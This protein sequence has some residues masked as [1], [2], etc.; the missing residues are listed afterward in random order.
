MILFF[1]TRYVSS[2]KLSAARWIDWVR[3]PK[4]VPEAASE[5]LAAVAA[6]RLQPPSTPQPNVFTTVQS[7][8]QSHHPLILSRELEF[9]PPPHHLEASRRPITWLETL[10]CVQNIKLGLVDLHPDIFSSNPR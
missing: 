10:R 7:S 1:Q 8:S 9:L 2:S 5:A 4:K 3:R 6:G